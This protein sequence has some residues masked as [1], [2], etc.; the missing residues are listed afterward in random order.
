VPSPQLHVGKDKN[1]T[2]HYEVYANGIDRS[3][4]GLDSFPESE[5]DVHWYT[6]PAGLA[7]GLDYDSNPTAMYGGTMVD[8]I[9]PTEVLKKI[10]LDYIDNTTM[11]ISVAKAPHKNKMLYKPTTEY[12][13][14]D[15]F[16]ANADTHSFNIDFSSDSPKWSGKGDLGMTTDMEVS[17]RTGLK[18][19]DW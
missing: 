4:F 9:N 7:S 1:V 13:K 12:L 15:K 16:N 3:A 5:D 18:K 10:T 19:I 14:Y 11:G 8:P 2:I 6:I 17:K